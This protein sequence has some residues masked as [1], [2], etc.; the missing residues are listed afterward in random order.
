MLSVEQ[1]NQYE[2]EGY[3]CPIPVLGADEVDV[4]RS[5]LEAFEAAQGGKLE[6]AQRNKSHLLFKWLDDLI[7][8][9]RIL[10]PIED[11]IGPDIMCWNT[12]F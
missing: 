6:P 4:L 10:D 11:L 8:D 7:R 2:R 5:K 3:I 1:K 12:L 9:P